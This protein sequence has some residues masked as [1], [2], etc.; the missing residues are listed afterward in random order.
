MAKITGL[1][2]SVLTGCA[3]V[4]AI[5]LALGQPEF[6]LFTHL[7]LLFGGLLIAATEDDAPWKTPQPAAARVVATTPRARK[8]RGEASE[9]RH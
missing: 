6:A 5:G 9:R 4:P 3:I 2:D 8:P 1:S 7:V